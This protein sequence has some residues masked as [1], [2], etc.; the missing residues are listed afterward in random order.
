MDWIIV[1]LGWAAL[2]VAS[3]L[4]VSFLATRW[5]RD[6]FGWALLAAAI[7]PFAII[8]LLGTRQSD[9]ERPAEFERRGPPS[10]RE[11]QKVALVA[12]D[13]SEQS[14]R[15]ARYAAQAFDDS[16]EIVLVTVFPRETRPHHDDHHALGEHEER[17]ESCTRG[18]LD[19]LRDA[20]V[21]AR[22]IVGFGVPGEEILRAAEEEKA[23]AII[24]GKRGAGFTKALIGSVSDYVLKHAKRPVVVV[25]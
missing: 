17:V 2:V 8:G 14:E 5:G 12:C 22:L 13:G 25:D 20:G 16:D 6:A 24:V 10:S 3:M 7:G 19:V 21:N 23:D 15:A 9:R 11:A 4:V 1:L 18:S